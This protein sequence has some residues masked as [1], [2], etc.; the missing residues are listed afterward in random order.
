MR[1]LHP[2][3][4]TALLAGCAQLLACDGDVVVPVDPPTILVNTD[5]VDF[6]EIPVGARVFRRITLLNDGDET[7]QLDGFTIEPAGAFYVEVPGTSVN[8]GDDLEVTVVFSPLAQGSFQS[9]LSIASN[10]SNR[11]VATVDL[12]GSAGVSSVCADCG[13]P[14]AP[15]C[16][17]PDHSEVFDPQGR[18]EDGECRYDAIVYPC[19]S[20]CDEDTGLCSGGALCDFIDCTDAG[21][22]PDAGP[23]D[24]GPQDAGYDAGPADAGPPP[25]CQ[26]P[27]TIDLEVRCTPDDPF[28]A[29]ELDI[30]MQDADWGVIRITLPGEPPGETYCAHDVVGMPVGPDQ[31][32]I[33]VEYEMGLCVPMDCPVDNTCDADVAYDCS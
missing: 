10:A 33:R 13:T 3:L 32:T 2:I 12:A 4:P 11:D 26:P 21:P 19:Q 15:S 9:T 24:A 16:L 30:H 17:T 5:R 6:G 28:F 31:G 27:C 8:G 29:A 1:L 25:A 20:G 18:C 14:P 7:L 23:Q 22:E